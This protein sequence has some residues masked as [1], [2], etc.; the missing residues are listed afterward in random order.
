M[1]K[2]WLLSFAGA[3]L[4][5]MAGPQTASALQIDR[6]GPVALDGHDLP[7]TAFAA[8][9]GYGGGRAY[10]GGYRGGYRVAG[11]RRGY[12]GGRTVA[13]RGAYHRGRVVVGRRYYGGVWYGARPRY[14][15]GRY[16]AYGAG[17]CWRSSPIGYIWVCGSG[18]GYG[19]GGGYYGRPIV[20]YRRAYRGHGY[21]GRPRVA[22]YRG[23]YYG[24]RVGFGGARVSH[25]R[26]G[27]GFRG[28]GRGR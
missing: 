23:G 12:H 17:S 2:G 20:A 16:W 19:Y 8:R 18:S 24:S 9:R 4:L 7:P 11:V 3:L 1:P 21:Y 27:G 25:Y 10:R 6:H 22:H 15:A 14:Y 26:G 28:G 13:V 5:A